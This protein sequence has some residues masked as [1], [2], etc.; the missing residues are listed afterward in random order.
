MASRRYMGAPLLTESFLHLYTP[1]G[2]IHTFFGGFDI[3]ASELLT[4]S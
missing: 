4:L 1:K 3:Y 2:S